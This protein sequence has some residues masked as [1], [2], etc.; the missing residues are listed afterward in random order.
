MKIGILSRDPKLYSTRRLREAC[1][2]AGHQVRVLD[3]LHFS[4]YL[5][6]GTPSLRHKNRRLSDC[7]AVIPRIGASIT[8]FGAAVVRQFEQMGIPT[9]NSSQGILA[10]RDKLRAGQLLS[11]HR[12][13]IPPT[14]FVRQRSDVLPAIESVGGA[15][16]VIKVLEGTQGTGVILADSNKGAEAIIETLQSAKQNVLIQKFIRE[17]RV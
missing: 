2:K 7:E 15:P 1:V 9:L 8:F 11:R 4:M 16:V 13:G 3:T 5:E 10:S 6:E 17:S 12:L 14:A